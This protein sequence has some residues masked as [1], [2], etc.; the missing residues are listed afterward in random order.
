MSLP[1]RKVPKAFPCE[2]G[3]AWKVHDWAGPSIGDEYC[4][5]IGDD[6]YG[7]RCPFFI[8]DNLKYLEQQCLKKMKGKGKL[9]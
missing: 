1:N 9:K 5:G 8:P 7:C 2:C 6:E 4:T 3:H